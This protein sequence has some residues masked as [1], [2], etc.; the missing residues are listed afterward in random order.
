MSDTIH[1]SDGRRTGESADVDA[2]T[3]AFLERWP[4]PPVP[5]GDPR[6]R[7]LYS[8]M[9]ERFDRYRAEKAALDERRMA[10]GLASVSES[11][12]TDEARFMSARADEIASA[13]SI[14]WRAIAIG[15]IGGSVATLAI[16]RA[17]R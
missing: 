7:W 5:P 6:L 2:D 10:A 1:L 17:L 14:P 9:W 13:L 4:V 3:A 12:S 11:Y 15:A 8:D 16:V